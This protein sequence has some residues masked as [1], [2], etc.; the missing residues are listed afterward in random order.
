M[1]YLEA[2]RKSPVDIRASYSASGGITT[3]VRDFYQI[4][5]AC[6]IFCVLFSHSK[7]EIIL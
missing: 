6:N 7:K 2:N 5:V 1:K 3:I 4:I